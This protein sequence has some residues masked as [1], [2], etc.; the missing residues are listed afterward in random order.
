MDFENDSVVRYCKPSQC[1][2]GKPL[3]GAFLLRKK[4]PVFRRPE[5]ETELSVDHYE[6]FESNNYQNIIKALENRNFKVNPNGY[7]A[8]IQ[9][10]VLKED[11]MKS[12]DLDIDIQ[13]TSTSHSLIRNLYN[14]DFEAADIFLRNISEAVK[15][16]DYQ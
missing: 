14:N 12:M 1:E 5:D 15:I 4:D 13:L 16:A 9:Y 6:F 2:N 11:I 10:A 7:L 3:A 8:K